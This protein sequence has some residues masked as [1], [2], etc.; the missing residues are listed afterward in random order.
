MLNKIKLLTISFLFLSAICILLVIQQE[1]LT[2]NIAQAQSEAARLALG[3]STS[4]QSYLELEPISINLTLSNQT[5]QT[6]PWRGA[7]G[8]LTHTSFVVTNSV[9]AKS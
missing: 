3:I 6:I 1:Q 5:D 8:S 7:L 4:Q 2:S 9:G